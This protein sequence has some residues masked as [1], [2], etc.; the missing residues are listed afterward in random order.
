M[1]PTRKLHPGI[2][3]LIII[4]LVGFAVTAVIVINGAASKDTNEATTDTTSQ[5]STPSEDTTSSDDVSMYKDGTYS[6]R[7]SYSSPGGL[8]SIELTVTIEN[9]VIMS[10]TLDPKATD[11]DAEEYQ[12]DFASAYKGFV[13]GKNVDEVSLSRVAGSS[14]TSNGFNK[15]LDQIKTDAKA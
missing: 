15:A 7:G 4:V 2:T 6:A 10:T 13:V 9:G 8:Q 5:T 1:E 11:G 12:A 3:A 14:L